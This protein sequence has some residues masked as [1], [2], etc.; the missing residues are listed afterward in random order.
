MN[1]DDSNDSRARRDQERHINTTTE[2]QSKCRNN[3]ELWLW[4]AQMKRE[5]PS[6][7]L[8]D[9][10]YLVGPSATLRRGVPDSEIS[11]HQLEATIQNGLLVLAFN[12]LSLFWPPACVNRSI[13]LVSISVTFSVPPMI[14]S[15]HKC[16]NCDPFMSSTST[17]I[18]RY[19]PELSKL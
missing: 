3:H 5:A 19:S 15:R 6:C 8:R 9:C 13:T 10:S 2:K 16:R 18:V 14:D 11:R 12:E 4:F 17:R 7:L 1:G